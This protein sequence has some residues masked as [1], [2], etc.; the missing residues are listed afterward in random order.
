MPPKPVSTARPKLPDIMRQRPPDRVDP[1]IARFK[2]RV[3]TASKS[4]GRRPI[5]IPD[6][7]DYGTGL[8]RVVREIFGVPIPSVEHVYGRIVTEA[9]DANP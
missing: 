5:W 9:G 1:G 4:R 6:G 8:E 7:T 3:G 2:S